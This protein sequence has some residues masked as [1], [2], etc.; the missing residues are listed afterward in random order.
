MRIYPIGLVISVISLY[1]CGVRNTEPRIDACDEFSVE[2]FKSTVGPLPYFEYLNESEIGT[3]P[4]TLDLDFFKLK[5]VGSRGI[6]L[7]WREHCGR[8]KFTTH[9]AEDSDE[10]L[11]CNSVSQQNFVY[12]LQ[13]KNTKADREKNS[14]ENCSKKFSYCV[15]A[16][17]EIVPLVLETFDT[18]FEHYSKLLKLY[19]RDNEFERWEYVTLKPYF[20]NDSVYT[21]SITTKKSKN[22]SRALNAYTVN[23]YFSIDDLYLDGGIEVAKPADF[24]EFVQQCS[25]MPHSPLSQTNKQQ[26]L[27]ILS[28]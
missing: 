24:Y 10:S 2:L 28:E 13:H 11:L 16:E 18:T 15:D 21:A 14:H 19:K 17:D 1:G 6:L 27:K 26:Y 7:S 12:T 22:N 3:E 25:A 20:V 8:L 5:S 9:D 23:W 4:G